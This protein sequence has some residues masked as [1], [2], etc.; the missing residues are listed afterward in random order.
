MADHTMVGK[1]GRVTGTISSGK[2]GEVMVSVRGGSEAFHAYAAD[3]DDNLPTGT[4]IV[5]VEYY[6]PRTVVVTKM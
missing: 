1:M 4:R 6:P 5:V 3:A 2:L